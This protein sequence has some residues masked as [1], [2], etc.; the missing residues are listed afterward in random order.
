[1]PSADPDASQAVSCDQA[2][3]WTQLAWR[4]VDTHW[5][6]AGSQILTVLSAEPDARSRGYLVA[7]LDSGFSV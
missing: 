2:T 1:M 4:N 5:L 3:D 6:V 7:S